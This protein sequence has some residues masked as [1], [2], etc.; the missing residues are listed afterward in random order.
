M[1]KI[2]KA[3]YQTADEIDARIRERQA[4]A[5]QLADSDARQAVLKEIVQLRM[6]AGAKR[7]V[8]TPGLKPAR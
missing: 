5:H 2:P 7:W 4:K 8:E 6:Y 1:K 3:S